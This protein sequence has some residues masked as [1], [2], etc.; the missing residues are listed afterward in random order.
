MNLKSLFLIF[1]LLTAAGVVNAQ[2][3]TPDVNEEHLKGTVKS[4][5]TTVRTPQG[6]IVAQ[7]IRLDFNTEGYLTRRTFFDTMGRSVITVDYTYNTRNQLVSDTRRYGSVVAETKYDY[8]LVDMTTT[9]ETYVNDS[10][11]MKTVYVY[12]EDHVLH[13]VITYDNEDRQ[14]GSTEYSYDEQGHKTYAV[15]TDGESIYKGTE[16]YRYDTDGFIAE[17]CS[18]FLNTLRQAFLYTYY[19]DNHGNWV[20]G[21]VYHV[22]PSEGYLYQV[23]N[24][25]IEYYE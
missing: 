17:R 18:Y 24:R 4:I 22:T 9:A 1:A 3:G 10:L 16:K 25:Q 21:Y 8:D 11:D 19:Y 7:P 12:D 2:S 13:E 14:I 23:I 6:R 5:I 20:Q 15:F